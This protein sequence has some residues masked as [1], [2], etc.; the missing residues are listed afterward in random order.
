MKGKSVKESALEDKKYIVWRSDLN[1][2]EVLHGRK[3]MGLIDDIAAETAYRHS[4]K[5]CVTKLV[6]PI[7]FI[8]PAKANNILILKASV[9]NAW[10]TSCEVGVKVFVQDQNT[11]AVEHLAS[12]YLVFVAIDKRG[13]PVKIPKAIPETIEQKRRFKEA[14]ERRKLRLRRKKA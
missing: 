12:G 9:N 4:G 7:E 13:K 2:L 11:M 3:I 6:D 14:E 10:D 1:K 5:V 8:R